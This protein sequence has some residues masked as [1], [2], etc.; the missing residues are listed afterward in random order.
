MIYTDGSTQGVQYVHGRYSSTHYN[1]RSTYGHNYYYSS[2]SERIRTRRTANNNVV[3][4]NAS[5]RTKRAAGP[6]LPLDGRK[7]QK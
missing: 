3:T 7:I 5:N 1:I 2:L 6:R 4:L